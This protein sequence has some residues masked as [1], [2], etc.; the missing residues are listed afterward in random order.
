MSGLWTIFRRELAGLFF[1]P[2][3][4]V[5]LFAALL[6]NGMGL[7]S[8]H[9]PKTRSALPLQWEARTE[10]VKLGHASVRAYRLHAHLLDRYNIV[11][12]VS[13]AGEILR[14]ELPEGITLAND[15]LGG[16]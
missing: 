2:L 5:L 7:S 8:L 12:F 4:W 15:Q 13:R 1:G 11:V 10:S 6:L 9:D 3:A 14:V 16:N